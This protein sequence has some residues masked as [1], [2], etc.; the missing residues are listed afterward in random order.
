[1][2]LSKKNADVGV[3]IVLA[4]EQGRKPDGTARV[5][6]AMRH[7]NVL[8]AEVARGLPNVELLAPADFMSAEALANLPTPH[9]YDRLVYFKMFEHIMARVSGS[10]GR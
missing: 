10:C 9:H 5:L 6:E 2:I 7:R 4:N 1:M 8:T 3:F